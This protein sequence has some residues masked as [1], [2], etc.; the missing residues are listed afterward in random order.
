MGTRAR[1]PQKEP[2]ECTVGRRMKEKM[3]EGEMKGGQFKGSECQVLMC[4]FSIT[5]V[6]GNDRER[7]QTA[8]L[9]YYIQTFNFIL[10][11]ISLRSV[12]LITEPRLSL[13]IKSSHVESWKHR[14]NFKVLFISFAYR[15]E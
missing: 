5:A 10:K 11:A 7:K 6:P 13:Y 1:G 12:F 2:N 8:T 15:K 14:T 9:I 4:L 3:K